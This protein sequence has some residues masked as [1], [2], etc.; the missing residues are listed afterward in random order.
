M[1]PNGDNYSARLSLNWAPS[2]DF[3]ADLKLTWDQQTMNSMDA[4]VELFCTG[5]K[6][7][8]TEIGA[9]M[10][11]ADCKKDMVKAESSLA[12]QYSVNWPRGNKGVPYYDS[13]FVLSSLALNKRFD[14]FD[15]TS[16]TGYYDQTIGGGNTAD[17]SP[18]AL[19]WST[20][21]EE[22]NLFTEELRLETSFDGPVNLM[23]GLYFEHSSR[24]WENYPDLFHAGLNVA[25]NNWTT[26]ET[27]AD[28]TTDSWSAFA[29]VQWDI[30][31]QLELSAGARYTDDSKDGKFENLTV[32]VSTIPFYP[33]GQVLKSEFSDDNT[34]P[35]VTLTW[36]PTPEHTVYAA[37]KTGYKA[38]GISNGALL[39]ASA[40]AENLQ[41]DPEETDGYE[42]GYKG[43]LF[44]G[45]LRVDLTGYSYDYDGLQL[46]SFNS[47]T[48][49]F[50]I[51]NAAKASTEGVQASFEWMALDDLSFSGSLGYNRARYEDYQNAQCY[52]GQTADTG[53]ITVG[54]VRTQDLTGEALTRAPDLMYSL[55]ADYRARFGGWTAEFSA[56]AAYTDDYQTAADNSPGGLQEDFW[57]L[58]A[59]VHLMPESEKYRISLIGRNLTNEYYMVNAVNHP[60][61][62]ADQFVGVFNRP[63]EIVFQAEYRF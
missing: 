61:G 21:Y 62:T 44:D 60:G 40:T 13:T 56:D 48:I 55:G 28:V 4:Y 34:S 18:F 32:G 17:F 45:T 35:E 51:G 22:Y 30:T 46:G 11:G 47:S 63:R 3:D 16:T 25:A 37:Y 31:E 42:V 2:D 1:G 27:V 15:L 26:V 20:Q 43:L 59:G 38:G 41:F 9:V 49:S 50:T 58:N 39:Q 52:V 19:I 14:S 23:G 36:K 5:S 12:T 10:P 53:C 7:A 8:P 57:R 24:E 29:Q 54:T 6:V 33:A